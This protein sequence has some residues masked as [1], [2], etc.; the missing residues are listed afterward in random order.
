M[1]DTCA[2][3]FEAVTP[4]FYSTYEQENEALPLEGPKAV[5]LGSGPIRI[6]QGIEFDCCCVQSAGALRERDRSIAQRRC[7]PR[8]CRLATR[9]RARAGSGGKSADARRDKR[10]SGPGLCRPDASIVPRAAAP[11]AGTF[12]GVAVGAGR[13]DT[14]STAVSR[15]PDAGSHG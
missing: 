3:E 13:G 5:I 2:A 15:C 12:D 11:W 6:G 4:Y 1:V 8:A 9:D 14:G 7:Q 10:A